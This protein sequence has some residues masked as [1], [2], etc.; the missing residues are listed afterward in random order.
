M[1]NQKRAGGY[2]ELYLGPMFSGKTLHVWHKINRALGT[3]LSCVFIKYINDNR[4]GDD[5]AIHTHDGLTIQPSAHLR[6]FKTQ[7]LLD[8][9]FSAQEFDI[10]VD[11]GQFFSDLSEAV[12]L[13]TREGRRIYIAALN[14]D[15]CR[16][17]FEPISN[18]I[19]LACKIVK[20][21]TFCMFCSASSGEPVEAE[22]TVRITAGDVQEMIGAQDKYRAACLSCYISNAQSAAI[23]PSTKLKR[24]SEGRQTSTAK[25]FCGKDHSPAMTYDEDVRTFMA[26]LNARFIKLYN[27]LLSR[28]GE[29]QIS[30]KAYQHTRRRDPAHL[31]DPVTETENNRHLSL[32]RAQDRPSFIAGMISG[33]LHARHPSG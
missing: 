7:K 4:F 11:E 33:N 30:P 17:P 3:G 1:T 9:Q 2:S 8:V 6:I 10:G 20:L 22:Y 16:K 28:R 12:N 21:T 13:W 29:I 14:G 23:A 32:D 24:R 25:T 27:A 15:F 5:L 31:L 26:V 18:T 19:P